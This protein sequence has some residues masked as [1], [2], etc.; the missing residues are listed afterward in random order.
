MKW[1]L[2]CES[3]YFSNEEFEVKNTFKLVDDFVIYPENVLAHLI[4]S[5]SS[6]LQEICSCIN[7]F[8][9]PT[10]KEHTSGEQLWINSDN[11]YIPVHVWEE[12]H[13]NIKYNSA[14]LCWI[15]YKMKNAL[16]L[17]YIVSYLTVFQRNAI[18]TFMRIGLIGEILEFQKVLMGLKKK[19]LGQKS[20]TAVEVEAIVFMAG[21]FWRRLYV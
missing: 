12:C 1:K 18:S 4:L 13:S 15:M 19:T 2:Y 21:A 10:S 3:K 9:L 20:L 17:E 11:Y 14:N 7:V 6:V 5:R 16:K 8:L